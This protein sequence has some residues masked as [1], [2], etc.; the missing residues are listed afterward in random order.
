MDN[1]F[2]ELSTANQS[3]VSAL[4]N[5]MAAYSHVDA[6]KLAVILSDAIEATRDEGRR[7]FSDVSRVTRDAVVQAI[8]ASA[9]ACSVTTVHARLPHHSPS[10]I[11]VA[12][13][14]ALREGLLM[15]HPTLPNIY[16]L[17]AWYNDPHG[18]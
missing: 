6:M 8:K 3:L 11:A 1:R 18:E 16:G 4:I 14:S 15:K 9:G 17:P 5:T 12:I 10:T 2:N 7:A 13:E